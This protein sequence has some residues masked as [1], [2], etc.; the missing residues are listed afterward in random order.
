MRPWI[1]ATALTLLC[2]S[3]CSSK[4]ET[5]YQPQLL[6]AS[7]AQRRAYYATPY[8]PE[9]T[10]PKTDKETELNMRRPKPGY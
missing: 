1:C 10:A 4:L 7:A 2:I 6:G 9:A 3:G 8:T 5:G